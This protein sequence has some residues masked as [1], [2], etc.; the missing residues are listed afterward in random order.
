MSRPRSGLLPVL[1]PLLLPIALAAQERS[2]PYELTRGDIVLASA[3]VVST[4]LGFAV[5]NG[6]EIPTP[7]EIAALD[8][9][10][11]N[12]FDRGATW[13]WSEDW[14]EVS[15]WT[16][17]G[18]LVAAGLVTFGPLLVDPRG[19]EAA[20]L[21]VILAETAAFTFGVTNLTK[22]ATRRK[23]PYLYNDAFTVEERA[24]LARDSGEGTLSFPSGHTAVAFAAAT[25]LS[26]VYAD[27]HGPTRASKWIWISSLG[28]ASLVG[29]ARVQGGMHFRTDVLVGA[30]VGAAIGHLVPRIHRIGGPDVG[31]VATPRQLGLRVSF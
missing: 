1:V 19:S 7:G 16:R 4:A 14:Q 22:A 29:V 3:G 8:R 25:F 20:T 12:R 30:A 9:S 23:R 10:S 11:V 24:E 21:G 18:L 27:L 2:F 28:V 6:V 26:T 5:H 31:L 15:D 17:D 13:N